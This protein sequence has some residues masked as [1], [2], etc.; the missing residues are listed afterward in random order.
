MLTDRFYLGLSALLSGSRRGP[1]SIAIGRGESSW[2]AAPPVPRRDRARLYKE[3]ARRKVL[4]K[5]ISY[6]DAAGGDSKE[7]TTRLR[8][9]ASFPAGEGGGTLREC[10]LW[11]GEG[12]DAVLVAHFIHPRVEKAAGDA[13]LRSIVLDLAPGRPLAQETPTRF[14]GNTLKEE[15][16][17]VV[18]SKKACQ[19]DEIRVDRRYYFNSIDEALSLG[20]DRCAFCFGRAGSDR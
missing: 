2:D 19:L 20:Y 15:I 14:M 16:H 12:E 17:D 13:L 11:I 6:V 3:V 8:I 10:G 9:Q 7:P 4:A 5:D 18:N 1:L